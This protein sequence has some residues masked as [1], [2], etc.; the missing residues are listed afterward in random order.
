MNNSEIIIYSTEDGLT[1]IQTRLENETVWLTQAQMA[2]LFGKDRTVITKHVNN[3]FEEG[4]LEEKSNVQNLHIA[5]SDKPVKFYNLDVIISVGYRVKSLQGTK[6]RQWATA[7]LRE[8]IVKGFTM[9]DEMLKQAGGGNYFEE[10]LARIRDIRSSEKVFWRKVLDIYATSIDY[11]A[12]AESSTLFFQT[13]QNKMHWAA[14]GHTA[15]E[16][17]YERIDAEKLNLGLTNFKGT[18]PTKQETEIAKNYL[19]EEE[20]NILNRM[21]TAYL[22]LAEIQALNRTPMYMSMWIEKLDEFIKITGNDIL[23]HSGTISHQQAIDKAHQ[24][25]NK[26]KSA[27]ENDLSEV[28]KHFIN[29][30]EKETKKLSL[31]KK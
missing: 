20:L 12:K 14:H 23:K 17:I 9:N 18:K 6:F 27:T 22:D 19:N 24:Q 15:A 10:L 7:R 31:T 8:Y 26:Y 25:Y 29:H 13:V 3:I 1:K 16:I 11:D 5:N 21:V 4:E 28:E 30:L 2:E